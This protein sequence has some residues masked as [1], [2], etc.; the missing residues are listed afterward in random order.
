MASFVSCRMCNSWLSFFRINTEILFPKQNKLFGPKKKNT[1]SSES[2]SAM[3]V[4]VL[5]FSPHLERSSLPIP[6]DLVFEIFSRLPSKAIARCCC[7][8]KFWASMLRS[9]D[10]T[11]LFL[12][13]SFAHPQLLFVFKEDREIVFFSS[14]Q[15]ENPEENSYVV[16]ANHLA[17]FPGR[18]FSCT[19]GFLCYGVN[20]IGIVSLKR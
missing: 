13:K 19:T 10:F 20:L 4:S 14:P 18:E 6:D 9:Q 8:S 1:N 3:N 5:T 11:E 2:V 12:T 15:P 16:A 17:R 7:I